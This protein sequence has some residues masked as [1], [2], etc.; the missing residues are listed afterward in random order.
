MAKTKTTAI[1]KSE[2]PSGL[3]VADV[4]AYPIV[5]ETSADLADV[6]RDNLGQQGVS[7]FELDRMR[8]PGSGGTKWEVVSLEGAEHVDALTGIIVHWRHARAYWKT[9]IEER[10]AGASK[11]PDCHSDDGIVGMGDPGGEC[12]KCPFAEWGSKEGSERAQACKQM[13]LLFLVPPQSVLPQVVVVPPSSIK[14]VKVYLRRLAEKGLPFFGAVTSLRLEK[15][16]NARFTFSRIVPEF[17]GAVPAEARERARVVRERVRKALDAVRVQ[18]QR[19]L[20]GGDD[21]REPAPSLNET[22]KE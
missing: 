17:A 3:A 6:I 9:K 2:P 7:E 14:P 1:A 13:L 5:G 15:T 8:V 10:S 22:A 20:T 19:D 21:R 16:S 12:A 11:A 4:K 18:D